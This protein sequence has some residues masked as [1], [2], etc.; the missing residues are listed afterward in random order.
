M[1]AKLAVQR[2]EHE[3]LWIGALPMTRAMA[4]LM[5]RREENSKLEHGTAWITVQWGQVA[6]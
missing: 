3:E 1:E 6:D 2:I 5:T 4:V